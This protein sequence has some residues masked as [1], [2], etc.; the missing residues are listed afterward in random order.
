[1]AV[2]YHIEDRYMYVTDFCLNPRNASLLPIGILNASKTMARVHFR[3][4]Y[5]AF[6]EGETRRKHQLRSRRRGYNIGT[7]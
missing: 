7:H 3:F 5:E 2:G 6:T 1:M 4:T